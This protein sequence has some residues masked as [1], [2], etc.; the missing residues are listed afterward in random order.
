MIIT[1]GIPRTLPNI[2]ELI[3]AEVKRLRHYA[4]SREFIDGRERIRDKR[5]AE[6]L[7]AGCIYNEIIAECHCSARAVDR[8]KK[9]LAGA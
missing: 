4:G 7:R 8:V 9:A 3:Y 6:M 5:I 1:Y 2:T